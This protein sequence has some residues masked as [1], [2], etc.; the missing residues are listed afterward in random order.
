MTSSSTSVIVVDVLEVAAGF[1]DLS[2]TSVAVLATMLLSFPCSP[3]AGT[4]LHPTNEKSLFAA[5]FSVT[6]LLDVQRPPPVTL[7]PSAGS[8]MPQMFAGISGIHRTLLSQT[9]ACNS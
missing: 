9:P 5:A 7:P 1:S 4:L 8:A 3:L 2:I 6:A